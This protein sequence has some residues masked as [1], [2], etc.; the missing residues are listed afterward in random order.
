MKTESVTNITA[1][2]RKI[3]VW[4]APVRVFHWLLALSFAGAYLTAEHDAWRIVH[5]T[6]GYTTAGLVVFRLLWGLIGS[7]HA[8]FSAFVR[9]PQAIARHV[10]AMLRGETQA[11]AG[12]N[13]LGALAII[14]MLG[15]TLFVTSAGWATYNELGGEWVEE[16]HEA[17]A[18]IMLGI[19]GIHIAGVLFA[20]WLQR[21]NLVRAMI[22]GYQH[23]A[24]GAAIRRAW[25]GVAVLILAAVLGFWW[26][27]WQDAGSAGPLTTH[28][29]K[30]QT[31]GHD[32]D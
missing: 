14:A 5:I 17:A 21:E 22:S 6:L 15:M 26:L 2:E 25:R 31:E 28:A 8:R 30:V 11:H 16:L 4:D 18:N 7:R 10:R 1:P 19:V 32:D 23:G 12:H 24:P 27:Q 29:A 13:P 3:L 20:S 9:G